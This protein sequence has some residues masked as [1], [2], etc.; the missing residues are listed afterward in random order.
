M[1]R[2]ISLEY[3]KNKISNYIRNAIIMTVIVLLLLFMVSGE[4]ISDNISFTDKNMLSVSIDVFTNMVYV[5]FT[6]TMLASFI[7]SGYK[8]KTINLMFSYPTK[9][10]QILLSQI[11]SVW[12]FNTI[13]LILSKILIY[14]FF[15]ISKKYTGIGFEGIL[16]SL[17]FY[18]EILI[19]SS[20]MISMSFVALF[21]GIYM[22]SSKATIISS[23]ILVCLTQ[24]NV[25]TFTLKDNIYFYIGIIIFSI[26]SILM[27][28]NNIETKDI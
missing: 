26:I 3:R 16:S 10:K 24:G 28:F 22:K 11:L 4:L 9:R 2:L 5:V 21:I 7:V 8:N 13:A 14:V 6:G 19:T 25:G 1:F 17:N 12:I 18:I 27:I 23:V 15:T 20:I